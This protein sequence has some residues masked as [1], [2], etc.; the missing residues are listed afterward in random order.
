MKTILPYLRPYRA[1]LLLATLVIAV[2][3]LCDLLLPTLMSSILNQGVYTRDWSYIVR[4]CGGMLAVAAVSLGCI[5]WGSKISNDVVAGFCADL[6]ADVFRKVNTMTFEA[7]GRLGTAALVTRATHDVSTVSWV[8]SELCGSIVTIPVLFFGGV[9]LAMRK[10]VVLSLILLAFI[11]VILVIVLAISNRILPL[12]EQ[13]DLYIDKQNSIMRERLRGIRII[14]AFNAEGV[15]HEKIASATRIMASNIIR[16]NV[17]TGAIAPLVTFLLNT[18]AVLVVYLGG[19]RMEAGLSGVSGGD[20]FAI[21]QYVALIANGVVMAAFVIVIYPHAKVAAQRI[22]QVLT[23]D[24]TELLAESQAVRFTGRIDLEGAGF[25]YADAAEPALS[26]IDMHVAPG[27]KIAVIGGTGSGKSTLAGLLLGF[28]LPTAGRVLLD[29]VSTEE[30]P[31]HTIRA[32]I[33]CVLQNAS[34]YSGTVL[35][36]MRMGN[37]EA[38]EAQIWDALDTAQASE[39][40]RAFPE[41]LQHEIRQSGKNLSGGQRQRLSIARAILKDAPIYI[42][43]DSFSALDFLTEARLRAALSRSIGGRTQI[44]ITQRATSAMHAD[45]IYVLEQGRL[46]GCGKH[47]ELLRSCQVYREI[48]ES[49]TGGAHV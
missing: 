27:E 45:R 11:P 16:S 34:I 47:D 13:A 33:R 6:R 31:R 48:Y 7:F 17:A 29:G 18:A 28:R 8:A 26:G 39:F 23:A 21:V 35:E 5:L 14:R 36:N 37:Q 1:K 2:S 40:V 3:T 9:I 43:D 42:F 10:D 46:A 30:L 24:G 44:I 38:S 20:I 22:R 25:R 41:G 4:C 12:W 15:E 19:I 32:N 49:Q